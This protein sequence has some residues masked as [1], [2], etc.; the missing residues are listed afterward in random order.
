MSSGEAISVVVRCRPFIGLEKKECTDCVRISSKDGVIRV[1]DP[2]VGKEFSPTD[3]K[4]WRLFTY[5]T[6]Y[7]KTKTQQQVFD[8][9]VQPVFQKVLRG[10]NSTIFCYGQTSSGKTFTMMGDLN[11]PAQYGIIPKLSQ[12]LFEHI[13]SPQCKDYKFAVTISFLEIYNEKVFD[14]LTG[15]R[16]DLKIRQTKSKGF[17]VPKLSNMEVESSDMMFRLIKTGFNNRST[18]ETKQNEGSSRSH[19]ILTMNI[20]K[21]AMEVNLLRN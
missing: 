1:G 7:D 18:S 17:H 15:S 12:A 19:S 16:K 8:K 2:S 20:V 3:I 6:V 14:L 5:D 9:S 21:E 10:L 4:T 13:K 11:N